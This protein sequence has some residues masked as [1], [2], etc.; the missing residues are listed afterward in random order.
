MIFLFN[1]ISFL[2]R[3]CTHKTYDWY[4]ENYGNPRTNLNIFVNSGLWVYATTEKKTLVNQSFECTYEVHKFSRV[5]PDSRSQNLPP[6]IFK[7][8]GPRL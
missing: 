6:D 2:S 1:H 3:F 7:H 8:N 5:F 4:T